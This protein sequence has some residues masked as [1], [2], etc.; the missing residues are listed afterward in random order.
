M[1]SRA[2]KED[3]R[4]GRFQA[5]CQHEDSADFSLCQRR[6]GPTEKEGRGEKRVLLLFFPTGLPVAPVPELG[7]HKRKS[8]ASMC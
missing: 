1:Q 7:R 6:S 3:R 8:A 5:S 2:A 4:L